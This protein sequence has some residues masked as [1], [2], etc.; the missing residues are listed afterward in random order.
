MLCCYAIVKGKSTASVCYVILY[1][2]QHTLLVLIMTSGLGHESVS[3]LDECK[4]ESQMNN[5]YPWI[6]MVSN[7]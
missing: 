1:L 7:V 4:G 6:L 5:T 2:L 3:V